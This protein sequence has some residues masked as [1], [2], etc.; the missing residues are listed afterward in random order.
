MR[1]LIIIVLIL[2]ARFVGYSQTLTD[3]QKKKQDAGKEIEFTSR[4]LKE[5]QKNERAS[6]SRLRLL[7][8]QIEQRNTI[9]S[10]INNEL[11]VYQEFIDNNSMV[12]GWMKT[13]VEKIKLEYAE[14]IR[15]AYKNRNSNDKTIFLLTSEN[16]NQA[17]RRF[18]YLKRYAVYRE[19]QAEV[20]QA[21]QTVLEK[22]VENLEQQKKTRQELIEQ[23]REETVRLTREK[24]QQDSEYNKLQNKQRDLRQK[25]RQQQRIEQQL[26]RQ[27]EKLI[28]EEAAKNRVGGGSGFA[29]TPEQEL[30]GNNF[31]QNRTRLP[32]PVERGIVT[33]H[34]GIH[35]H[36]VLTNVQIKNNGINI[37]TEKNSAVRA[38]FNGEISRVFGITGG[39]TAVIIRHG[40]YL[41]V[42]S[43]LSEVT[44]K[45]GD[46]VSTRQNI[47]KVFY[48]SDDGNKSILKFQIWRE[49]QKLD[50]E[51]WI[52]KQ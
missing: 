8:N 46:K 35:R 45:K 21:I 10:S 2:T 36:P 12:I 37:A 29:L 17:Y 14:L 49:N 47:G 50:P 48:D 52:G 40:K 51:N 20:I 16:V 19:S 28:E 13:D 39:N 5:V 33:E 34:F 25:L 44:V 7:N 4:L 18:L 41:S 42:Y 1:V 9:I 38:I 27:I 11:A 22:K 6:L 23:T 15:S 31:E 32:W 26:E 24:S 43:N 30:I 3:L